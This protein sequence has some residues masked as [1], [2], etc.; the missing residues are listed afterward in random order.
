MPSNPALVARQPAA[1]TSEVAPAGKQKLSSLSLGSM[2]PPNPSDWPHVPWVC[3]L[4]QKSKCPIS[5]ENAMLYEC[6]AHCTLVASED[7]L[8]MGWKSYGM[9]VQAVPVGANWTMPKLLAALATM[10]PLSPGCV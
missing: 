10:N 6:A 2:S 8:Y 5:S 1:G 7:V 4:L 9:L 3:T